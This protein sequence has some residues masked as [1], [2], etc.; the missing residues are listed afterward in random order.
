VRLLAAA[1]IVLFAGVLQVTVAPLFP[2]RGAVID[3][4]LIAIFLVAMLAGPRPAM[5]AVP[6]V[7]ILIS[8]ATDRAPG[9][10]LLAY[11]PWLPAATLV[12]EG[13]LPLSR[14]AQ[15]LAVFVGAGLWAR[16]VLSAAAMADGAG[17][18]PTEM[19][20]QVLVPGMLIDIIVFTALWIPLRL[21]KATRRDLSLRQGA[22]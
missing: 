9:I 10:M 13:H 21:A 12:E 11:L 18:E 2:V 6:I 4:G 14:Y 19:L 1:A 7:A 17:F 20:L 3:V 8:F 15:M 5:V 16:L 22:W